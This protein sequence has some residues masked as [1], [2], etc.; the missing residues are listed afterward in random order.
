ME[1]KKG[2]SG[3]PL[4]EERAA[5]RARPKQPAPNKACL[6]VLECAGRMR[7]SAS[8]RGTGQMDK[9]SVRPQGS[10]HSGRSER[11]GMY[12]RYGRPA[13]DQS[14]TQTVRILDTRG[15]GFGLT[16]PDARMDVLGLP[17]PRMESWMDRQMRGLECSGSLTLA[18]RDK[19]GTDKR[20]GWDVRESL[21]ARDKTQ[22]GRTMHG[23]T[24]AVRG[25]CAGREGT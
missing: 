19:T 22:S 17:H 10:E 4:V 6:S 13:L 21:P 11:L 16:R 8:L 15:D 24:Y 18:G 7:G 5:G 20:A 25:S 2:R 14:A 9:R 23:R 3:Q 12:A 1:G